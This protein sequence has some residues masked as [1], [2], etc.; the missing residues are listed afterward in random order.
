MSTFGQF[1]PINSIPI[2]R[3]FVFVRKLFV[4]LWDHQKFF[5]I[6][7]SP[8]CKLFLYFGF[9]SSLLCRGDS[10]WE[11]SCVLLV[12]NYNSSVEVPLWKVMCEH[13]WNPSVWR[14]G[15]DQWLEPRNISF[16]L[17]LDLFSQLSLSLSHYILHRYYLLVFIYI[18][19]IVCLLTLVLNQESF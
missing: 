15:V 5:V 2:F 10:I 6:I 7:R 14:R 8:S 1:S 3:I 17:R 18:F 16:C 4:I 19:D 11:R 9:V 13:N 12:L